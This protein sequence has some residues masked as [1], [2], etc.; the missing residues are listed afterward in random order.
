MLTPSI[1][2]LE[3]VKTLYNILHIVDGAARS[4]KHSKR[5]SNNGLP[6]QVVLGSHRGHRPSRHSPSDPASE[7]ERRHRLKRSIRHLPPR[8]IAFEETRFAPAYCK[9]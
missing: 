4:P 1:Y 7:T 5:R 8:Y 9:T 2:P 3:S 6:R